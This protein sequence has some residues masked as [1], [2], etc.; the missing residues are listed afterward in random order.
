MKFRKESVRIMILSVV[1]TLLGIT[2]AKADLSFNSFEDT[3]W[4]VSKDMEKGY[5]FPPPS[6]GF[7]KAEKHIDKI[8]KGYLYFP[9]GSRN[10]L[11]FENIIG[12]FFDYEGRWFVD[13]TIILTVLGG[14]PQDFTVIS[15]HQE[16]DRWATM[17]L[18][19]KVAEDKKN[20]GMIKSAQMDVLGSAFFETSSEG[21]V[22]AGEI[23][24]KP[25]WI[26]ESKVPEHVL[27]ILLD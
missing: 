7:S 14:T 8:K 21:D 13:D 19:V 23:Q 10:E 25:K 11:D 2:I 9:A 17:I 3:W 12:V 27:E 20:P 16:D 4:V 1:F 18:R 26:P 22:F 24:F 5:V 6:E 15:R